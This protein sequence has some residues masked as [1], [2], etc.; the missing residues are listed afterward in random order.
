MNRPLVHASRLLETSTEIT[1][2][3]Q[4]LLAR[5]KITLLTS[6]WKTGK[7]TLVSILLGQRSRSAPLAGLALTSGKTLVV[8]EEGE[9]LWAA[10]QKRIDMGDTIFLLQPFAAPPTREQT[11]KLVEEIM[12][13]VQTEGIDLVVIDPLVSFVPPAAENNTA[14]FLAVLAPL[15]RLAQ[16]GVAVLLLHHPRKGVMREGL[17]ARGAGALLAFVDITMEMHLADASNPA[18]RRRR[19]LVRS[20]FT[21]SPRN[22]LMELAADGCTYELIAEQVEDEFQGPWTILK[23]ALEDAANKLTRR[24]LIEQWPADCPRPKLA[25]LWRWLDEAFARGL[26]TR[27][28]SGHRHDPYRYW[29][30]E[31][32]QQW[33]DDPLHE[34][35]NLEAI[36]FD[37][38]WADQTRER[39][40]KALL[41]REKSAGQETT[42][43]ETKG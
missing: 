3:W 20:R 41:G 1:W 32:E 33:R 28:G 21:Q 16:A 12:Q 39:A 14:A 40:K 35:L 38:M 31:K 23:L 22:L 26:I 37:K 5:G 29:L 4:G 25:S 24:Q 43:L 8:S 13:L 17:C 10:R 18:V 34:L 30:P 19:L 2:L 9:D 6:L 15:R 7:T 42:G 27:S 11:E 36:D